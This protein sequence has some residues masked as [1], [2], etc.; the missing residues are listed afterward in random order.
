MKK[1]VLAVFLVLASLASAPIYACD[2]CSDIHVHVI[3]IDEDGGV[4]PLAAPCICGGT[5]VST[6]ISTNYTLISKN[7]CIHG[8]GGLDYT[9]RVTKV[10][11]LKC[12]SCGMVSNQNT[13]TSTKV[14]CNK[15]LS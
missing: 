2:D 1:L 12:Q 4:A 13:T 15:T 8:N 6:T 14:S 3:S 7:A 5:R 10:T 9:Y 11:G